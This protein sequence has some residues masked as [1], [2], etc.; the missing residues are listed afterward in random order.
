MRGRERLVFRVATGFALVHAL[1]DAFVNRQPGVPLGEHALAAVLSLAG[2][3]AAIAAFPRLRPGVRAVIS[4]AFGVLAAANGGQHI[5][6]VAA[7]GPARSDLTGVVA[8][9][10][11]VVLLGLALWIPFGHRGERAASRRRR[12]R[13]R[14]IAALAVAA[15]AYYVL[16]PVAFAIVVT[17]KFREPIDAPPAAAYRDVTFP[18]SDGLQLAGWYVPSRNRAAVIVVHGGGGDRTGGL[19]HARLL[20]RHGYGVLLYDS[21]GRGESEGS[22]N[23][24]GWEWDRD[25]AGAVEFLR[26]RPDVDPQRL[27]GLGLSTGADVLIA[28]AAERRDLKAI[29][30]DGATAWSHEDQINAVGYDPMTPYFFTLT[31]AAGAITSS[32]P[33]APLK[34]LVPDVSPTPLFL[35]AA[36]SFQNEVEFNRLYAEAAREPVE[37]WERPDGNHTAAVREDPEEYER[38]VIGLFD[39]AL[40]RR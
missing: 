6:H 11:G 14:A 22:P 16:M 18:A 34:E 32:W 38:R 17:H 36:G 27:G 7:D 30:C 4:L 9:A 1:D 13:N 40:L 8:T 25:V 28:F 15:L 3:L 20:A 39:R 31:A 5:A 12:W 10:A 33:R 29:V 35:I 2:A 19:D 21:R 26:G 24:L 23:A 37:L